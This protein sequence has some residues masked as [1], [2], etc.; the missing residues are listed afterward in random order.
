M[1]FS[2]VT[3]ANGSGLTLFP[4]QR[5]SRKNP[6]QEKLPCT[7]ESYSA[8]LRP[9]FLIFK[10]DNSCSLGFFCRLLN[11]DLKGLGMLGRKDNFIQ[12]Y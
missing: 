6:S 5:G 9:T 11:I 8:F 2:I 4:E 1:G 7:L 10:W 12:S 3:L